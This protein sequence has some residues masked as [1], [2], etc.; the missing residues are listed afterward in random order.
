M[1]EAQ[2][3]LMKLAFELE[4]QWGAGKLDLPKLKGL[5]TAKCTGHDTP[6]TGELLG[7]SS[8]IEV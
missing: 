8:I 3:A 7:T 1:C 4:I 2:E 5:A 6:S